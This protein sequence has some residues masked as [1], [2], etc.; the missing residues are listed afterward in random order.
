MSM[1]SINWYPG[2]MK[3]NRYRTGD[4]RCQNTYKQQKS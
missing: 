1:T 3:D 2:H 4:S